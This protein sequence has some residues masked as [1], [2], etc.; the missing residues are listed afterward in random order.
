MQKLQNGN[1]LC[2]TCGEEF[3][4]KTKTRR[5]Q[6]FI[7]ECLICGRKNENEVQR[8][9]GRPGATHK[10]ANIEIFRDNLKY[11]ATALRRESACGFGPNLGIASPVLPI[12]SG[13]V[14]GD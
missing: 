10:G 1:Y 3:N 8:F 4:P 13:E 14:K 2:R 9:L 7:N 12:S 5:S 6:G 11:Y